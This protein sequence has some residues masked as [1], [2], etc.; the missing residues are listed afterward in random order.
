MKWTINN[1]WD[2]LIERLDTLEK[3]EL[4][5]KQVI[6]LKDL[7]N[8]E[9][10]WQIVETEYNVCFSYEITTYFSCVKILFH[11][12]GHCY[13]NDNL[14]IGAKYHNSKKEDVVA[15]LNE[16]EIYISE[17]KYE[18]DYAK[19]LNFCNKLEKVRK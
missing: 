2:E 16:W 13:Y 3:F 6:L 7:A 12:T 9:F 10:K 14:I 19:F 18:K 1:T 11:S 8:I 4:P 5:Y 15:M 17:K